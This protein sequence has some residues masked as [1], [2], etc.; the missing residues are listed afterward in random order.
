MIL[1]SICKIYD[2]NII[3]LFND[4][5]RLYSCASIDPRTNLS[6]YS[7]RINNMS[8]Y[9]V[10]DNSTILNIVEI[11]DYDNIQFNCIFNISRD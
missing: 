6:A 8:D 7:D 2:G 1:E 3:L 5:N 11:F 10:T 9:R 4:K